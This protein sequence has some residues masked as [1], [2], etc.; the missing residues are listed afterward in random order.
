ML[1]Q[2]T[3]HME[4]LE[5]RTAGRKISLGDNITRLCRRVRTLEAG[6][7][8]TIP[9]VIGGAGA[10]YVTYPALN[11]TDYVT[12]N[13]LD[14]WDYLPRVDLPAPIVPLVLPLRLDARLADLEGAVLNPGGNLDRVQARLKDLKYC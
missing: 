11:A 3:E 13:T 4:E 1:Q 9:L 7:K 14:A 12:L 10:A 5:V 6:V 2:I 8:P